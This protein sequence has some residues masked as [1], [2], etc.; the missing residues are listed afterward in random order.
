MRPTLSSIVRAA[1]LSEASKDVE[2]RR[3]AW[4][5][6][7]REMLQRAE[8]PQAERAARLLSRDARD[9]WYSAIFS[10]SAW[11][12][13]LDYRVPVDRSGR[14]LDD[15]FREDNRRFIE[16]L[17][18]DHGV[19][20]ARP[21]R[22]IGYGFQG[23]VWQLPDGNVM[24]TTHTGAEDEGKKARDIMRRQHSGDPTAVSSLRVL[25]VFEVRIRR[26]E[27]GEGET[28]ASRRASPPEPG[29]VAVIMDR[30]VP[31]DK[32]PKFQRAMDSLLTVI[33]QQISLA[34]LPFVAEEH[35]EKYRR[36]AMSAKLPVVIRDHGFLP[37]SFVNPYSGGHNQVSLGVDP[38]E[39]LSSVAD[40][41]LREI[42]DAVRKSP[43]ASSALRD[44]PT[45][46]GLELHIRLNAGSGGDPTWWSRLKDGIARE[47]RS[48]RSDIATDNFGIDSKG[49]IIPFDM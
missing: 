45:I 24:K 35:H 49:D 27:E 5:E 7:R 17:E 43:S 4:L 14:T 34:C 18:R 41:F 38:K 25:D 40:Q 11:G 46:A 9:P 47:I 13:V 48:G 32:H 23:Q 6:R 31:A 8:S 39:A 42:D 36:I 10:D 12:E 20:D 19:G 15:L 30:I 21:L 29:V 44:L 3:R 37:S 2:Q 26:F 1:I 22:M 28:V 33:S 16:T